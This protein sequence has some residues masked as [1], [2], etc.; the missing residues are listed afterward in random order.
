MALD[1]SK[2]LATLVGAANGVLGGVVDNAPATDPL[3]VEAG[4]TLN[5]AEVPAVIPVGTVLN[6]VL[7][8]AVGNGITAKVQNATV[9]NLGTV[10][11]AGDTGVG[12]ALNNG[13][14]VTNTLNATNPGE[15]AVS[16]FLAGIAVGGTTAGAGS[17]VNNTGA[18]TATGENGVGV[19]LDTG[20]L[21]NG[22]TI[23][24][25]NVGGVGVTIG[26]GKVDNGA[27]SS[28]S[29][30]QD[31]LDAAGTTLITNAGNILGTGGNGVAQAAGSVANAATG[32]IT[33]GTNGVAMTGG[34]LANAE[35]GTIKGAAAGVLNTG[36]GLLDNAGQILAT[37]GDG[38]STAAGTLTNGATGTITGA[39]NGI[40]GDGAA[41][42][43]NLGQVT[44]QAASGV[45]MTGGAL[46]NEAG[47]AI[48]GATAGV[49]MTGGDLT[50]AA[51]GA[52]TGAAAGV[53]NTG[54]GVLDN[55]GQILA[56]TGDGVSTAAG[57][58]TNE[59][60]G[61][62]TGAQ[63]G[64]VGDGTAAIDNLGQVTG[65]AASGIAMTGGTLTNEAGAAI[66]GATAGVAMAAD[67]VAD[68]LTNAGSI[69]GTGAGAIGVDL[70]DGGTLTNSGTITGTVGLDGAPALAIRLGAGGSRLVLDPTAVLNGGVQALGDGNTLEIAAG[71]GTT[72][73][74]DIGQTITGFTNTVL[75]NGAVADVL[76]AVTTPGTVKVGDGA[77]L[78][79]GGPVAAGVA[80][81]LGG[82]GAKLTLGDPA[83]FAGTIT[84]LGPDDI[85]D[86]GVL[87]TD[88]TVAY[89]PTKGA[90]TVSVGGVISDLI[91][92]QLAAGLDPLNL[93]LT[94]GGDG[95]GGTT[96]TIG[97]GTGTNPGTGTGTGTNPGTGTGTNPGT[98]TG[99][100]PG[101]GTGTNPGT[102]TGTNPGT[103]TGIDPG[104][105]T[106]TNPG[107]GTGID[108]GTG[109]GTNPGTGTG[110]TGS[111]VTTGSGGS[112]ITTTSPLG[113]T[114]TQVLPPGSTIAQGSGA[115][116]GDVISIDPGAIFQGRGD[117]TISGHVG[118]TSGVKSVTLS[119]VIDGADTPTVLG[120]ATVG[121]DGTYTFLDHVG[122][123]LQGF[124]TATQTDNNGNTLS[125]QSPYSLQAGLRTPGGFVTDQDL[126]SADGNTF[127]SRTQY[128]P[129]GTSR[130]N[131]QDSGQTFTA[132]YYTTFNNGGAPDNTFVFNP[133]SGASTINL[134][135]AD[136]ADH[137]TISLPS[138]DFQ[139]LASVIANTTNVRG[140]AVITDPNTGDT[141]KLTGVS[142]A[143]LKANPSDFAFHA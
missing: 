29:G 12:I 60:T 37:T 32:V 1:I 114:T 138:S 45:A 8:G 11:G 25:A 33:G 142:K 99:I 6:G 122:R 81:D 86:L 19:A 56:T 58:L 121:A 82:T 47:A 22:G 2:T 106:G 18:V 46:T 59:A 112:T 85:L 15:G 44:G 131:I 98:G 136:G 139:D 132:D 127:V 141:I 80:V 135:R 115:T 35:G 78:T 31:G 69:A 137:D 4:V 87:G 84:N 79:L 27:N 36:A 117:F 123:H 24:A 83:G 96:V 64:I 65:Q 89:D 30:A 74:K 14:T 17:A 120:T 23:L 50:N 129:G 55:A 13:G 103:G 16:G 63:N 57:T 20:A 76:G 88:A 128:R 116:A 113:T 40:V 119:A 70:A 9:T 95:A 94:L 34:D 140:G 26:T 5:G 49:A 130:V 97:T 126:Y 109:T 52:I 28:I 90:I 53:L 73:I 77:S 108:P 93:G 111:T 66:K 75:D 133:G 48:N 7:S 125:V 134:F 54:A 39:Q 61:T 51:D 124:I 67:G 43:D 100:D 107:T 38:V 62:I 68:T 3:T 118:A 102:G 21:T 143:E 42:I 110:G 71:D 104:T 72:A 10:Q 101:T 105:G 41:T 92:V 91:P